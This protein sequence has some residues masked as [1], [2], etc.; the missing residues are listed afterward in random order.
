MGAMDTPMESPEQFDHHRL[1][2]REPEA[3]RHWFLDHADAVYTFVYYRTGRDRE[4]AVEIVQDTF[5]SALRKLDDYDPARGGMPTW[6]TFVARNCIRRSMRER[7]RYLTAD[8]PWEKI[9]ARLVGAFHAL[10][11]TPL[12]DEVV[13]RQ[14]TAELVQTTLSNLPEGYRRALREHYC[15]QRSVH[16]MATARSVSEGAVKSLLHRS[17]LAFKAAFETIAKSF[18]ETPT[19]RRATP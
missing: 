7:D 1:R 11:S 16:E 19:A 17:R 4:L 12:P 18:A 6:L 13:E 3:L 5:V 10:E 14:E 15:E 2:R 8:D 9:D